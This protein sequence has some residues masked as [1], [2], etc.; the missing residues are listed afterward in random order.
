VLNIQDIE[1]AATRLNGVLLKTPLQRSS[2]FSQM[3]GC[4]V[5]LKC[6]NLQKTGSFKI[7]GAYN[8]ISEIQEQGKTEAVVASSAGNHAQGVAFAASKLGVKATIVMPKTTPIAKIKATEGYGA[9]VRLH[10]ACYDDAYKKAM[11]IHKETKAEFIHPFNDPTVIAGQGTIGYDILESLPNVDIVF[12]PAGGGGLLAGMAF[13]LK[14]IN[15]RIKVIGVQAEGAAAIKQSFYEKKLVALPNVNT[16]AD[17][18]AVKEPGD[19]TTG[20][21]SEYAD[22]VV[23]V[24][25]AEISSAI[26]YLLERCK[27]MVEPAG[28]ASLAAVLG[29][30]ADVAGKRCACILSGGNID[31]S[32]IHRI[33]DIGLV[34]RKRKLKFRT[35][36]PDI[37]GSLENFAKIM[38]GNYANIV[39]VQFDRMSADLDPHEVILHIACEV[40]DEKHGE[41]VV[42]SLEKNGY[43]VIME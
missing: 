34:A 33:I 42:L 26:L 17:G 29:G 11:E 4:E 16:I 40:G 37:P 32:F 9:Q 3:A 39:R 41:K 22:D 7:R 30:K 8:K 2:T 38:A 27:L 35:V 10:G 20:I 28:A 15:P 19:I 1:K 6:E 21:I 18:I 24:S 25:D 13:Y 36:M 31:V 23:T 5:Y 43:K 14:N 12:V